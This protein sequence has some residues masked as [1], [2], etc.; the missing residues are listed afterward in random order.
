[1]HPILQP[2]IDH[3][4]EDIDAAEGILA[5]RVE[6]SQTGEKTETNLKDDW[7]DL[8]ILMSTNML[9]VLF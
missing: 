7:K 9:L 4:R 1:M 8:R 2:H 3:A 5:N 6:F